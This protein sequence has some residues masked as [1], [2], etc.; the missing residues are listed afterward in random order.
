M[1]T[2]RS[3]VR[4]TARRGFRRPPFSGTIAQAEQALAGGE[5]DRAD[6]EDAEGEEEEQG[7]VAGGLVV[8]VSEQAV[9]DQEAEGPVDDEGTEAASGTGDRA[10]AL[11]GQT[12]LLTAVTELDTGFLQG[13]ARSGEP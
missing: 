12:E 8:A 11:L 6:G 3:A 1:A 2:H 9:C 13:L 5:A 7:P 4:R 10:G